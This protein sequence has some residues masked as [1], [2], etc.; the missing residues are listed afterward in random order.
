M[1]SPFFV[2]IMKLLNFSSCANFFKLSD[3]G[4]G[5]FL[6]KTFFKGVRNLLGSF[7]CFLKAKSGSGI[8]LGLV[9]KRLEMAYPGRY[10]PV[11]PRVAFIR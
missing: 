10:Q 1:K 9:K 4:L 8:G 11:I 2:S 5:L 3:N 6:G 7:F